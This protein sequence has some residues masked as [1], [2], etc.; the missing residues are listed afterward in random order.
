MDG[1]GLAA[2]ARHRD[3][4]DAE[5]R[6]DQ[7]FHGRYLGGL[8]ND[9]GPDA[10]RCKQLVGELTQPCLL[11]Q[12]DERLPFRGR[13]L[14][15]GP[16]REPMPTRDSEAEL[17]D[18]QSAPTKFGSLGSRRGYRD[19][20]IAVQHA[21]RDLVGGTLL[22]LETDAWRRLAEAP[23]LLGDIPTRQGV[24]ECQSDPPG[25][26]IAQRGD[27]VSRRVHFGDASPRVFEH[28][29]AVRVQ[30]KSAV[31][32]VEQRRTGLSLEPGEGSRQR[33]LA[34]HELRGGVGDMFRLR[35]YHEPAQF[36]EVHLSTIATDQDFIAALRSGKIVGM[37]G[38]TDLEHTIGRA[39]DGLLESLR[40]EPLGGDR[41]RV[42]SEA[43]RFGRVFGGQ[44]VAQAMAAAATTVVDK[45][46]HSLHAYFVKSGDPGHPLYVVVDRV[47]DGRSMA[48]RRV[49][50]EQGGETLL[51][52]MVSFH[53][54]PAGPEF[55]ERALRGV[56]P[57]GLP[58]L[59]DWV[60]SAPADRIERAR[61]WISRP[62]PLD[63]RIAEPTCFFGGPRATGP[64]SHWM[65]LPR[66]VGDDTVL[67]SVLLA[68]ATDY[69]LLDIALRGHPEPVSVEASTA[70]SLDHSIWLHRRVR[71]DRWHSHT[72][73]LVAV[74]GHRGLV[75]GAVHDVDGH[76]VASTA[77]E[78]LIRNGYRSP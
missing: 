63:M 55:A 45:P 41:F 30:P 11:G 25:V 67:H 28:D 37:G 70:F 40:P 4:R 47:R 50:V 29:L 48:A 2:V 17:I 52:A 34:H 8:E 78:V 42:H 72:A 58:R 20:D 74:S 75:R 22:Q 26:G 44:M 12:C 69:L 15:A 33:R 21:M 60:E 3:H 19:V 39:L 6:C 68:Y 16:V 53:E 64:R 5:A 65:R 32:T 54:N 51:I 77:Q 66:A 14:Q 18:I 46:P 1:L 31:D 56:D 10:V 71:F 57:A 35:E 9:F 76:L 38:L 43:N 49:S 62:P 36:G 13:Q 23:Q 73:E 24:Q 7:S 59:Q 61:T 27:A